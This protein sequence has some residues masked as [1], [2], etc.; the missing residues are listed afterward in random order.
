MRLD[1]FLPVPLNAGC[2]LNIELPPQ[3]SV[4][5]IGLVKTL[6]VFGPITEY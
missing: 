2:K 6:N 1:F 4:E 3:Y 5:T